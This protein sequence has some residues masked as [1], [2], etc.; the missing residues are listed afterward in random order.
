VLAA[1]V[2]AIEDALREYGV[3]I[4]DLPVTPPRLYALIEKARS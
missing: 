2:S 1:I 4:T 3:K